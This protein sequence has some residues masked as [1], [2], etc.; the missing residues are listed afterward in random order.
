MFD[1]IVKTSVST[2]DN[3]PAINSKGQI[4]YSSNKLFANKLILLKPGTQYSSNTGFA[5]LNITTSGSIQLTGNVQGNPTYI[6]QKIN[7]QAI[8]SDTVDSFI[9]TNLSNTTVTISFQ[10]AL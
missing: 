3:I 8:I 2:K 1:F 6:N 9:I 7:N 5:V 10:L 4:T